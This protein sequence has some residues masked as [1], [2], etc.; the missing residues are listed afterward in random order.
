MNVRLIK[1]K[2]LFPGKHVKMSCVT[3]FQN[4]P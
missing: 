4:I 2:Q 3:M 1:N